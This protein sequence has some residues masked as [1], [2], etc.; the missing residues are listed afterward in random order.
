MDWEDIMKLRRIIDKL[1][2]AEW[3][4]LIRGVNWLRSQYE[5]PPKPRSKEAWEILS[6]AASRMRYEQTG[7]WTLNSWLK[8]RLWV[9]EQF[10]RIKPKPDEDRW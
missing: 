6:E 3:N 4:A 1:T 8:K 5:H 2:P 7:L 9:P 10:R